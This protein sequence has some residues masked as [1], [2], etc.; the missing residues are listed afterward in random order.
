M[1]GETLLKE[2]VLTYAVQELKQPAIPPDLPHV[3]PNSGEQKGASL[4]KVGY[5]RQTPSKCG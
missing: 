5:V 1:P 3:V 2:T 4:L